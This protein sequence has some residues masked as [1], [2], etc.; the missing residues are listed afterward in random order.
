MTPSGHSDRPIDLGPLVIDAGGSF[1]ARAYDT[2]GQLLKN[3]IHK[4]I[5]HQGTSIIEIY[6][7]CPIFNKDAFLLVIKKQPITPCCATLAR[8]TYTLQ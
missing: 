3:L 7:S 2:Q 6:Q 4:A 5:E 8:S 1:F